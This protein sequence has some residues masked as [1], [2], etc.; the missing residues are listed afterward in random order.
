MRTEV[1]VRL[2]GAT[3]QTLVA[4]AAM[5][6]DAAR[7]WLDA[8]YV[9]LD[10]VPHRAS[11]KVLSADKLLSVADAAGAAAFADAAWAASYAA[12]AGGVLGKA[13]ITVDVD[14]GTVGY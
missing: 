3:E 2:P 8:E 13:L 14:A 4:N 11:G 10:C 5:T 6:L 9:R 1:I 12:A 7:A